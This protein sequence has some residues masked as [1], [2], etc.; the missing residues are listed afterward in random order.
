MT[1]TKR[2]PALWAVAGVLMFLLCGAASCA[3]VGLPSSGDLS[4][5]ADPVPGRVAI[6]GDSVTL[7]SLLYSGDD[8]GWDLAEKVGLGWKA[9]HAQ[10]RLTADV[11]GLET[12]PSVLVMAFGHNYHGWSPDYENELLMLAAT[13]AEGSCTVVMLPYYEGTDAAHQADID[14]YRGWAFRLRDALPDR[15]V[16]VDATSALAGHL[17]TDGV[18]LVEGDGATGNA[19]LYQAQRGV[20]RCLTGPGPDA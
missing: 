16:L 5:A 7:Q 18:H 10:P 12:S 20:D 11:D 9:V 3:P 4:A 8:R 14:A 1:T 15:I 13:P 6:A 2:R 19:F 17:A